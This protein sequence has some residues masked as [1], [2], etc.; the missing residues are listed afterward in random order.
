M[1]KVNKCSATIVSNMHQNTYRK[2]S[3]AN[4]ENNRMK[5][6]CEKDT[7]EENWSCFNSFHKWEIQGNKDSE[8][9][10][11][12]TKPKVKIVRRFEK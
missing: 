12:V 3:S 7:C 4:T 9:R 10:F 11:A 8:W 1:I 2:R 6:N 5:E